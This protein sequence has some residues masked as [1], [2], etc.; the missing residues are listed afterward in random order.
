MRE[1]NTGRDR[2]NVFD[3]VASMLSRN[4]DVDRDKI[5]PDSD[6]VDDLGADS[7]DSV[8]IVME[9]EDQFGIEIKDDE[10]DEIRTVG[11]LVRAIELKLAR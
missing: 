4:M 8:E 3:D 6:L 7:L 11:Q 2:M 1:T 9:L 10:L 5:T